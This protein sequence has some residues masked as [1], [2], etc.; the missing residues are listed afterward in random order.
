MSTPY[1]PPPKK[2]MRRP[3][4]KMIGGVCSGVADYL[5]M[6]VTL[7]R[8]LTVVIS[9]FT[10]VPIILYIIALFVVPEEGAAPPPQVYPPAPPSSGYGYTPAGYSAPTYSPAPAPSPGPAPQSPADPVWGNTGAP[11]DQPPAPVE[12]TDPQR[13]VDPTDPVPTANPTDPVQPSGPSEPE[14]KPDA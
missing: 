8:I 12:P 4:N 14:R 5:N 9:L 11:W 10:G 2:L 1:P 6:D 13:P 7:V 3:A